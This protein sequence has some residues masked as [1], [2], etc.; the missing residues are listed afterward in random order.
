[1]HKIF[2]TGFKL[3]WVQTQALTYMVHVLNWWLT[4]IKYLFI[5]FIARCSMCNNYCCSSW[6][7]PKEKTVQSKTQNSNFDILGI[8]SRLD[9]NLFLK[10]FLK[11]R[12]NEKY[13]I[14]N[15]KMHWNVLFFPF[16]NPHSTCNPSSPMK[17]IKQETERRSTVYLWVVL[18]LGNAQ[19]NILCWGRGVKK[20]DSQMTFGKLSRAILHSLMKNKLVQL[21]SPLV[22]I[23]TCTFIEL[24]LN[25]FQT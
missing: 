18:R 23:V 2:Q 6:F 16:F 11:L 21:S 14:K 24:F 22:M 7:F 13:Q 17:W 25:R 10:Q 20:D 8:Q 12:H 15:H 4:L 3:G 5:F 19:T 9:T 1:M